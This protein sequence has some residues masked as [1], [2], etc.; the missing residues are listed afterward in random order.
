MTMH[1]LLEGDRYTL[2]GRVDARADNCSASADD[3]DCKFCRAMIRMSEP[4]DFSALD[5]IEADLRA[6][7][8]ASRE[9]DEKLP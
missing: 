2:C 9:Q 4:V 5:Q 7:D 3:V 6:D 1:A 8:V